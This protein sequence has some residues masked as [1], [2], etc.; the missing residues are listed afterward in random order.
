M[1]TESYSSISV[2]KQ[3]YG[4]STKRGAQ[5]PFNFNLLNPD[6]NNMIES[7]DEKILVWLNAVPKSMV[8]NW[9]VRS[10]SF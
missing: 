7:I 4:N 1:T 2:L 8:A 10:I 5:I 6:K 9:V 3:Y